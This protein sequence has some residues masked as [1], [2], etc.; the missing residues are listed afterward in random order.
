VNPNPLAS[1]PLRQST[2]SLK[3]PGPAQMSAKYSR[4]CDDMSS[5]CKFHNKTTTDRERKS[6]AKKPRNSAHLCF[7]SPQSDTSLHCKTMNTGIVHHVA[8]LFT[9]PKTSA[10]THCAYRMEEWPLDRLSLHNEI[11]YMSVNSHPSKY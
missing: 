11:V 10:G 8:C 3:P 9:L 4:S 1:Q 7:L 6:Q 2:Y 5:F